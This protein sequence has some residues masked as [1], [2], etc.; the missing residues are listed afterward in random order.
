MGPKKRE[1]DLILGSISESYPKGERGNLRSPSDRHCG[2]CCGVYNVPMLEGFNTMF[3][4]TQ[5]RQN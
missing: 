2:C 1:M 4:V 3:K 5:V